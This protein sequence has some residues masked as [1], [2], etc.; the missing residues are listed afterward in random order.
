M[1]N[2]GIVTRAVAVGVIA[3]GSKVAVI[4][5]SAGGAGGLL[6]GIGALAAAGGLAAAATSTQPAA[7]QPKT[8]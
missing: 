4:A 7:E 2:L 5:K 3:V 1:A 8:H 6:K